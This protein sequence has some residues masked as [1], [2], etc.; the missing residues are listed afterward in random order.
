M[1]KKKYLQYEFAQQT[2]M[3]VLFTLPSSHFPHASYLKVKVK[4]NRAIGTFS[5]PYYTIYSVE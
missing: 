3:V 1:W 2:R 4:Q 5:A